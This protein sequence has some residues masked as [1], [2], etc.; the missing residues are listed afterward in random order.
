MGVP[1]NNITN[2]NTK[3]VAAVMVTASLPP[4]AHPGNLV[5]VQVSTLG[6]A[7]SIKGGNLLATPLIGAD[8]EVYALAQ[9]AIVIGNPADSKIK[10]N[11]TSGG[12]PNGAIVEKSIGF[13]LNS[14]NEVKLAL[15]N[16]DITTAKM[17]A[18]AI[19]AEMQDE[20]AQA[21]DPGT[22]AVKVPLA[23]QDKVLNFLAKIEGLQIAPD[24]V[25]KVIIDE[26]SGTIVIGESVKINKVA[27]AQGNLLLKVA[28]TDRLQLFL[29]KDEDSPYS[30]DKVA[31]LE[32][33]ATLGDLV[34]G[35]NSLG[36]QPQDLIAILKS[37]HQAGALQATL[38]IK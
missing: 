34:Q 9:G 36:V 13:D 7:K 26:A 8:G 24:S 19:N 29:D 14:L 16:P 38:E 11:P 17:V 20:I 30:Q 1:T 18:T 32:G 22:V 5:S 23:F 27:I 10:A 3:N 15:K 12:I 37:I 21:K 35:L 25:A 6:D 31:T 28:D 4:F 33:R 2:L